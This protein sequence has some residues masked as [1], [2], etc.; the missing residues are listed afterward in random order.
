MSP[1]PQPEVSLAT[2]ELSARKFADHRDALKSIVQLLNYQVELLKRAA[3]PD[4]RRAL[5]K[6]AAAENDL[7]DL[8]T[9][10]PG[11]F[12][13]PRTVIFHGIKCGWEKGKGKIVF[14]N[15]DRVVELIR[16]HFPEMAEALVITKETP[17]KKAL[18]ELAAADLKR[19]GISI[20][21]TGDQVIIRP[22][23]T[24]VDKFVTALL[25]EATAPTN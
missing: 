8:I 10:V 12:V 2:I 17:N 20:E 24:S 14:E 15:P 7:R 18:A 16:K 5:A 9:S 25:A 13:R 4:I 1:S 11:L 6:A 3:L 19:L 22:V 23:D 21:D